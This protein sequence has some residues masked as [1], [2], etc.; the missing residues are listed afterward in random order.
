[1][2]GREGCADVVYVTVTDPEGWCTYGDR[3]TVQTFFFSTLIPVSFHFNRFEKLRST[4]FAPPEVAFHFNR[5][6]VGG[7]RRRRRLGGS[8]V[9][10]V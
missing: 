5:F 1:M 8:R 6:W 4:L 10:G 2:I 7:R 3:G 9:S